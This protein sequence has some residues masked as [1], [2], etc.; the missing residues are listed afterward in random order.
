MHNFIYISERRQTV[1]I[2]NIINIYLFD[3]RE[4]AEALKR[5]KVKGVV[6]LQI[7]KKIFYFFQFIQITL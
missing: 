6:I 2:I 4:A 7:F 1:N 5:A 3:F